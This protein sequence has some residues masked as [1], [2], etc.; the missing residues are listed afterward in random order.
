[1]AI[2]DAYATAATYRDIT[3]KT[4]TSEDAEILTDL[5]AV[6]RFLEGRLHRFFNKD[7]AERERA[8]WC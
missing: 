5:K 2:S 8:M 3:G 6:S 7:A 4:D 1:M